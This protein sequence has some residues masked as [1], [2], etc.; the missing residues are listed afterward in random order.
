M[1]QYLIALI[2]TIIGF[3]SYALDD[4]DLYRYGDTRVEIERTAFILKF[5]FYNNEKDLNKA[6]R[7]ATE[8]PED[9]EGEVRAFTQTREGDDVCTIHI[10]PPT[11]WDDRESLAILGH[12]SL[13]CTYASHQDAA[14]E[15]EEQKK[16]WEDKMK[17][18]E[19]H[20]AIIDKEVSF[21]DLF[22]EDRRLEL[23]WLRADY[24][25]LGIV[26][27]EEVKK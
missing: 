25:A 11:T 16:D 23:E 4:F 12:E 22:A 26:I 15:I 14:A 24:E 8:A 21:E 17:A 13:H 7:E 20:K 1:K 5:V 3:N 2:A 18:E 9:Q 27:D 19:K 10:V 6:F